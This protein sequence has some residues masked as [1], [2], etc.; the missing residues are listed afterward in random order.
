MS[1]TSIP[2]QKILKPRIDNNIQKEQIIKE[3]PP[4]PKI[5]KVQKFDKM[6]NDLS[7][8]QMGEI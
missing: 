3:I 6:N 7:D 8:V 5:E 2:E 1:L 4:L